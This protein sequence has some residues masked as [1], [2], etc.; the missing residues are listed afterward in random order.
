MSSGGSA[1]VDQLPMSE[2]AQIN[3]EKIQEKVEKSIPKKVER[4]EISKLLREHMQNMPSVAEPI[5]DFNSERA[6]EE[7]RGREY[8]DLYSLNKSN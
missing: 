4:S 5:Y 1:I 3:I 7:K 2:Y 6:E 8:E